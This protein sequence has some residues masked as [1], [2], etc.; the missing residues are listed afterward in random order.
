M[1]GGQGTIMI[2][3]LGLEN[4]KEMVNEILTLPA[5]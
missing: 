1:L 4:G 5:V 3:G 2:A